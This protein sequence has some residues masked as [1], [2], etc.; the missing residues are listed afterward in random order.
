MKEKVYEYLV[1]N[2]GDLSV[3]SIVLGFVAA[4]I[5]GFVI[6][7]SYRFSHGAA[8]YSA[9][10]NVSLVMITVVTTLIMS[11]IGNNVALS[12]GMVGALSIVRFR[13]AIKD[14][15][16]TAYIFWA[17][18]VG[19]CC[20]VQD[21]MVAGIG[22]GVIFLIMLILGNVQN[23][24]RFL[25]IVRGSEQIAGKVRETVQ[26]YY[27]DKAKLRVENSSKTSVEEIFEI[28]QKVITNSTKRNKNKDIK[29]LLYEIDGV[30]CVNLVCQN[31]EVNR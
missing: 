29:E 20:G 1:L 12:L 18:A 2:S 5:I 15:R 9:K 30:E 11:V 22:S 3:E 31:D 25:L 14:P 6:F 17:V 27:A 7:L 16:D 4:T 26:N 10:F 8:V 19:I 24:D 13:T 28:S 21:Y 23:N